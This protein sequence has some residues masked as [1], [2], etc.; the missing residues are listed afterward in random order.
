MSSTPLNLNYI[1][2]DN[3]LGTLFFN[4]LHTNYKKYKALPIKK[5]DK[6]ECNEIAALK[7]EEFKFRKHQEFV[8]H[9]LNYNSP[10][11]SLLL[12]HGLGSGK[13]CSALN[14]FNKLYED[15]KKWNVYVLIKASLENTPWKEDMKKCLISHYEDKLKCI[16]F[17]HYDAPNADVI[18]DR[19]IFNTTQNDTLKMFIIDEVHN[20]IRNVYSNINNKNSGRAFKIYNKIIDEK[21][22]NEQTKLVCISATPVINNP[23]EIGL[24]FNLLR[25][26]I[27]P[28]TEE[29]FNYMFVEKGSNPTIVKKHINLFQRR[30]IG[31]VSYYESIN[32][33]HYA[34]KTEIVKY[35]QMSDYQTSVYLDSELKED[36]MEQRKQ[37]SGKKGK[38]D[39]INRQM[40]TIVSSGIRVTKSSDIP[41]SYRTYTRQA[42]NFVFP[43]ISGT[44]NGYK[45]PRPADFRTSEDFDQN[46]KKGYTKVTIKNDVL[47]SNAL[48]KI[49][50]SFLNYWDSLNSSD[51]KNKT[52]IHNEL[53]ILENKY[54][55]NIDKFIEEGTFKS[56]LMKSMYDCS[57]KFLYIVLKIM[58]SKGLSMIY[59]T[60]VNM[61]GI[62]LLKFYLNYFDFSSYSENKKT[63]YKY[64][65]FHGSVIKERSQILEVFNNKDN[66]YG[67]NIKIILLSVAG[68]EGISLFNVTNV[69]IVEPHWNE[70]RI[71]QAVGRAIRFCSHKDLPMNE[72]KVSVYRY[73]STRKNKKLTTDQ[74]LFNLSKKKH[75]L[76]S[77]FTDAM[78]QVSI[79]CILNKEENMLNKKFNCFK[80]ELD[81][82]FKNVSKAYDKNIINDLMIHSGSNAKYSETVNVSVYKIKAV[83]YNSTKTIVKPGDYWYNP[84]KN[85]V[86]DYDL[87]FP[88]GKLLKDSHGIPKKMDNIYIITN[89]IVVPLI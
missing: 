29:E 37:S 62:Q 70:I 11:T 14:I 81:S 8:A 46:L 24:L 35:I 53:Q 1:L 61:E 55:G 19:I 2:P 31:L 40:N 76:V 85:V 83:I 54:K 58:L 5:T 47:Y 64:T 65:E 75:K 25:N 6:D 3:N 23:F 60:Y 34:E 78:K 77:T 74:H 79:D 10:F 33:M 57:S 66:R 9:F 28:N 42:G 48:K 52:T 30:I 44:I 13:T 15:Y 69:H 63:K 4:W 82:V 12:Y 17:I 22:N 27:F 18:F 87:E 41:D 84:E 32:P 21:Q 56:K 16:H 50:N 39:A 89:N 43:D 67:K 59:S 26:N 80:F 73:L 36:E 72:R 88:I 38:T 20:F 68:V 49:I 71:E 86:F 45:R 51:I 7:K